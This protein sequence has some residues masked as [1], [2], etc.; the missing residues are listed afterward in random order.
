MIGT[1]SVLL[2]PEVLDYLASDRSPEVTILSA[3]DFGD[4]LMQVHLAHHR[5]KPGYNGQTELFFEPWPRGEIHFRRET[6]T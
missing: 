5:L 2:S 4:G 3:S 6:D 1:A